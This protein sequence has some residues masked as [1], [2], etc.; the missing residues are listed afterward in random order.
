MERNGKK[1]DAVRTPFFILKNPLIFVNSINIIKLIIMVIYHLISYILFT[2]II[3]AY[4]K[5]SEHDRKIGR[6]EK[7]ICN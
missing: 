3:G 1:K 6:E 5:Q 7:T 2:K 4:G